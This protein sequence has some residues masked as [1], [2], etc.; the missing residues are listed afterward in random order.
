MPLQQF[1]S[2]IVQPHDNRICL[3]PLC[4]GWNVSKQQFFFP[5]TLAQKQNEKNMNSKTKLS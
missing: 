4:S 2:D 3:H 1:P 5:E